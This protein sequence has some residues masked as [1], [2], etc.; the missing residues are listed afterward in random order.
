MFELSHTVG[1]TFHFPCGDI[2]FVWLQPGKLSSEKILLTHVVT[3][4]R[5]L[6]SGSSS[7]FIP[8]EALLFPRMLHSH[9]SFLYYDFLLSLSISVWLS[10]VSRPDVIS[11]ATLV[12]LT[13]T[14]AFELCITPW[15]PALTEG[16]MLFSLLLLRLAILHVSL[17]LMSIY[18]IQNCTKLLHCT[19][20][21]HFPLCFVKYSS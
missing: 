1:P 2:L 18:C 10:A 11:G 4:P 8:L 9:G 20:N 15:A 3:A 14:V 13:E 12:I 19:V 21:F 5:L 6:T 17:A 16:G 7:F